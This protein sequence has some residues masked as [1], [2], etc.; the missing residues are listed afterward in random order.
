[1][2][3]FDELTDARLDALL[4]DVP[5]PLGLVA[6][7]QRASPGDDA[8]DGDS[9]L[10]NLLRDA[11]CPADLCERLQL[12]VAD[13]ALDETLR[14][15]PIPESLRPRLRIIPH[16]RPR[17]P[18]RRMAVAAAL[19]LVTL[20]GYYGTLGA[21]LNAWRTDQ[22][23]ETLL[24][25]IDL[26]PLQLQAE[27]QRP[28]PLLDVARPRESVRYWPSV[29]TSAEPLAV[30]L[31]PHDTAIERGPAGEL[32]TQWEQGVPFAADIMTLRW[33]PVA[34]PPQSESWH[35]ELHHIRWATPTGAD[36]PLVAGYDRA[37]LLRTGTH[38]PVFPILH[39]ELTKAVTPLS[40]A[41]GS[42]A[43]AERLLREGRLPDPSEVR[44]EDFL[45]FLDYRYPLPADDLFEL[46]VAGG[47]SFLGRQPHGLM[48]IGVQG[49]LRRAAAPWHATIIVDVSASMRGA[50]RLEAVRNAWQTITQHLGD[51]DSLSLVAVSHDV[52]KQVELAR[53]GQLP[54]I[55]K[56][57]EELQAGGGDNLALGLQ[58]GLTL[59]LEAEVSEA[60]DRRLVLITD[61]Q[62]TLR[63][64]DAGR[65]HGLI[66]LAAEQGVTATMLELETPAA[67]SQLFDWAQPQTN[68]RY[69][70]ANAE[71]LPWKLLQAATGIDPVLARDASLQVTFNPQAVLAYRLVGSGPTATT[72]LAGLATASG[73]FHSGTDA[74]LLYEVWL[75]PNDVEEVAWAELLWSDRA[76][77]YARKSARSGITRRD[78]AAAFGASSSSLQA[79]AIAAEIGQRLRGEPDFEVSP[80][81][82]FT[83]RRKP[84]S[85]S[86]LL[87]R[88]N[89][90]QANVAKGPDWQ[91]LMRLVERLEQ[92]RVNVSSE[93]RGRPSAK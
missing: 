75:R 43:R 74:A 87:S 21:L 29:S 56:V 57:I 92:L 91:R 80:T 84:S 47:P 54:A 25:I 89:E 68:L 64:V 3:T 79:A 93:A 8:A 39:T 15:V 85:W 32:R 72:G 61:G 34:A 58:T 45:A 55:T 73:P 22:Q 44:V 51:H 40:F 7:L 63:P 1:M 71:S 90:V 26:G 50:E 77:G 13:E 14:C 60:V 76:S 66:E 81:G 4:R 31:V 48:Q 37:Y 6:R 20:C 10:D 88:A 53:R 18:W 67:A 23:R 59:T 49:A 41:T 78:F 46:H 17:H 5:I 12:V 28:W 35:N 70:I 9:E 33:G 36:L 52:V 11:P 27:A 83:E 38:P 24:S 16:L 69:E 65:M 30:D 86:D 19:F 82:S 62:T 2:A 42:V